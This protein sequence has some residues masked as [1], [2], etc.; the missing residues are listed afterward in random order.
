MQT[1][2]KCQ[3]DKKVLSCSIGHMGYG[4]WYS[5]TAIFT[6]LILAHKLKCFCRSGQNRVVC[7]FTILVN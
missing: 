3:K 1:N 6:S 2:D 7:F 5:S 4:M